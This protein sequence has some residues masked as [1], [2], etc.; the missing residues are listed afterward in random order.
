MFSISGIIEN[1]IHSIRQWV[2]PWYLAYAILGAVSTAIIPVLLPLIV[3]ASSHNLSDVAWVMGVYNLGILTSPLWG[4]LT[5]KKH[6]PR[7]IFFGGFLALMVSLAV[8]PFI[9]SLLG[10]LI[11]SFLLGTSTAAVVT[12]ST[13]FVVE[14]NPQ[15]EWTQRIGWL[16]SFNGSGQTIGLFIAAFFSASKLYNEGIWIGAA[17]FIP[18]IVLGRL[19]LPVKKSKMSMPSILKHLDFRKIA[20][21]GKTELIGGGI[22]RHSHFLNL[23]ALRSIKKLLT[24]RLGFF[25]ITW[26]LSAFGAASF[27]AYFPILMNTSYQVSPGATSLIYAITGAIGIALYTGSTKLSDRLGVQKVYKWGISI[28][29]IGFALLLLLI[30]FKIPAMP[31][32]AS[33]AFAIIILSWPILSVTSTTLTAE[34]SPISEGEAM[35]L[36]N[37]SGAV[38]T[39]LGTFIGGPLINIIGFSA[40]PIL[41]VSGLGFSLLL[42]M[43]I[44]KISSE[45]KVRLTNPVKS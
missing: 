44:H 13:L 43:K 24:T 11:I 40:I 20:N 25:I 36:Y 1:L 34:L 18:A 28:R 5:D 8:L 30:F 14:Y 4:N 7:L 42:T 31:E 32:I 29:L 6:I 38:A 9:N 26:F 23:S 10:W 33:L 45:P 17:L 22:I 21:F 3:T 2:S 16:Q 12:V 35:G 41:G 39:V 27:F 37:A 15:S 19:G